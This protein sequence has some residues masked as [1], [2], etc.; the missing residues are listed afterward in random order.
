MSRTKIILGVIGGVALIGGIGYFF[1]SRRRIK[2]IENWN[3][4]SKNVPSA[5]TISDMK[6]IM[7]SDGSYVHFFQN[8]RF[9]VYSK[10][11]EDKNM[12]SYGYYFN[13]GRI[14]QSDKGKV[15]K[16]NSVIQ[17]INKSKE[18]F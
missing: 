2:G 11:G 5:E 10:K 6:E 17:N 12:L 14:L 15:I 4:V 13:G 9:F 16:G 3:M 18:T 7:L 1:Y 8:N